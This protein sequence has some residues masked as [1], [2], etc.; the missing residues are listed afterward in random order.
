MRTQAL[1]TGLALTFTIPLTSPT[2]PA[3]AAADG[4][5]AGVVSD[6]NGDG[7]ADAVVADTVRTHSLVGGGVYVYSRNN[8][9]NV[10][11][12]GF[13]VPDRADVTL[14][15]ILTVNLGAGTIT[16]VVNDTGGQVDNSN[17]GTPQYVVDYPTP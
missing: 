10:T 8:P 13:D 6:V 15:H 16:H 17:T 14:H 11:T 4:C 7:W 5:T 9:A 3:L 12:S 1:L 2:P